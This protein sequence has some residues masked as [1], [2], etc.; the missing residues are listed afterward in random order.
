M[1]DPSEALGPYE[2]AALLIILS[3]KR[4]GGWVACE[5]FL[6][7]ASLMLSSDWRYHHGFC[8]LHTLAEQ[9]IAPLAEWVEAADGGLRCQTNALTTVFWRGSSEGW[10]LVPEFTVHR[11]W[12]W[13]MWFSQEDGLPLSGAQ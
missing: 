4:D 5:G 1:L 9:V 6:P 2:L 13:Q 8:Q 7:G 3:A 11:L 10:T 12:P